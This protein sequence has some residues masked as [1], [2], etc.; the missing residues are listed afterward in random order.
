MVVHEVKHP[1]PAL[2]LD[3]PNR[4]PPSMRVRAD[5]AASHAISDFVY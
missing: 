5:R 4:L 3:D 1:S 2:R